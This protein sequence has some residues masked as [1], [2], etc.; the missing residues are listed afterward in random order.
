MADVYDAIRVFVLEHRGCGELRGDAEP[1]TPG[2]NPCS[3]TRSAAAR[4]ACRRR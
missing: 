1:I 4:S 3:R 2:L